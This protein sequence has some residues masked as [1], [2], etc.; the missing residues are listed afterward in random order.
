MLCPTSGHS[1]ARYPISPTRIV[2]R[3][4]IPVLLE[5]PFMAD[6]VEKVENTATAKISQRLARSEL[7]QEKPSWL[8]E[9]DHQAILPG[10]MWSPTSKRVERISSL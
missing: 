8:R 10:L 1:Q 5:S 3:P 2:S 7:W 6:A 4:T 9:E